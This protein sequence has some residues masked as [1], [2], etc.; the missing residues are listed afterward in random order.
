MLTGL[1]VGQQKK[2]IK[3]LKALREGVSGW[4]DGDVIRW[5][6][7]EQLD[8]L[9]PGMKSRRATG[10]DLCRMRYEDFETVCTSPSGKRSFTDLLNPGTWMR[11]RKRSDSNQYDSGSEE[12]P[13]QQNR[14]SGRLS[15]EPSLRVVS[16]QEPEMSPRPEVQHAF[17]RIQALVQGL[18]AG[19]VQTFLFAPP[20]PRSPRNPAGRGRLRSVS[21]D[22]T[23]ESGSA[24]PSIALTES[25]DHTMS[26][27]SE[28]SPSAGGEV[29]FSCSPVD[30]F[31]DEVIAQLSAPENLSEITSDSEREEKL[32]P[33]YASSSPPGQSKSSPSEQRPHSPPRRGIMALFRNVSSESNGTGTDTHVPASETVTPRT[34]DPTIASADLHHDDARDF[35]FDKPVGKKAADEKSDDDDD[36]YEDVVRPAA[37]GCCCI[38]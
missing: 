23:M 18:D 13:Q 12:Q 26:S 21:S 8:F 10:M 31:A 19:A 3:K 6:Q 1:K 7:F 14:H 5:L 16:E 2:L 4:S 20:K 30:R 33:K 24:G 25:E 38:M 32:G 27:I 29:S 17:Q 35:K 36:A 37:A 9:V 34:T 15:R 28:T 11:S 22:A